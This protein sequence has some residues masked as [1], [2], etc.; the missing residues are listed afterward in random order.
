M[1]KRLQNEK[2]YRPVL[3]QVRRDYGPDRSLVEAVMSGAGQGAAPAVSAP[4][5]PEAPPAPESAPPPAARAERAPVR[6]PEPDVVRFPQR[7]LA[8]QPAAPKAPRS[9]HAGYEP[10]LYHERFKVTHSERMENKSLVT[11]HAAALGTSLAFAHMM[12]AW[13][14]ILKSSEKE[15][16]RALERTEL[17]RPPNDDA[18]GLADFENKLA[19]IYLEALRNAPPIEKEG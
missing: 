5:E 12:R 15:I 4:V 14:T 7:E 8:P 1:A 11:R 18:L 19:H 9:E 6:E 2:E 16:L 10:A 13:L 3:K 17:R